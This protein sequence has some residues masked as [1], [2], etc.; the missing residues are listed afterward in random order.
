M[1]EGAALTAKLACARDRSSLGL[2][3]ACVSDGDDATDDLAMGQQSIVAAVIDRLVKR[4]PAGKL[5]DAMANCDE[6]LGSLDI[7]LDG[8]SGV[9]R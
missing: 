4:M 3:L 9:N 7:Y 1:L 8:G 2:G 5:T 6:F